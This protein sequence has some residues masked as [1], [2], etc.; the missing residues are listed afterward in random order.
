MGEA[1]AD[2]VQRL[3][4]KIQKLAAEWLFDS[5][6]GSRHAA[7]IHRIAHHR[8]VVGRK[9][10]TDLMRSSGRQTAFQQRQVGLPGA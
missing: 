5:T 9:M 7:K 8:V 1:Q 6:R 4:G 2:R 3:S 10:D